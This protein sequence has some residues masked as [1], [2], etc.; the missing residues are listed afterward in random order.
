MAKKD[1]NKLPSVR[2]AEAKELSRSNKLTGAGASI[3]G[4]GAAIGGQVVGHAMGLGDTS[5][6]LG[7]GVPGA[8]IG[9]KAAHYLGRQFR[10][11]LRK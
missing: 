8:M 6:L 5:P 10:R 2:A 1:L 4:V 3:G 11:K 9:S 7:L